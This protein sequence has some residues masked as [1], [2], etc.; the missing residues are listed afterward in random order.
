MIKA[1]KN[2]F[3]TPLCRIL[4]LAVVCVLGCG[5]SGSGLRRYELSGKVIFKGHPLARGEISFAPDVSQGNTGPGSITII[6]D[7]RYCTQPGKGV[8]GGHYLV[9]ITH[10]PLE[11]ER[12][13]TVEPLLFPPC[14]MVVELPKEDA[15]RDFNVPDSPRR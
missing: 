15:V 12:A 8:V 1:S 9:R 13:E 5:T 11:D 6:E 7:G 2:V 4:L 3:D 10:T 14:E